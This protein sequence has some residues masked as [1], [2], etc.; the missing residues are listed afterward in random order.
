MENFQTCISSHRHKQEI[1]KDATEAAA[2]QISGTPSFVLARSSKDELD[3]VK[4]VGAL[5]YGQ[6]KSAIDELLKN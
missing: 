5:P 3:G 4:L 2:I 6:F 1:E